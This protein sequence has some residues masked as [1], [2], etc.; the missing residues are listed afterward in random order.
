MLVYRKLLKSGRDLDEETATS[1]AK[2]KLEIMNSQ[3]ST[4]LSIISSLELE[5][6]DDRSYIPSFIYLYTHDR[7]FEKFNI[8][9]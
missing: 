5:D 6:E 2:Y 9:E 7:I 1:I 3:Q 4:I 8:E